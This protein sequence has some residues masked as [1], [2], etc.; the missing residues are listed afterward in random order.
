LLDEEVEP[1]VDVVGANSGIVSS[2]TVLLAISQNTNIEYKQSYIIRYQKTMRII[3][4][5]QLKFY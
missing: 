3:T 1:V 5:E 2:L 4:F